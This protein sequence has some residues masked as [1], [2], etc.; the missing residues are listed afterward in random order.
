MGLTNIQSQRFFAI[1][2]NL[3]FVAQKTSCGLG[4]RDRPHDVYNICLTGSDGLLRGCLDGVKDDEL[5]DGRTTI[6]GAIIVGAEVAVQACRNL[7]AVHVLHVPSHR[8][9]VGVCHPHEF[10][11][12]LFL[13]ISLD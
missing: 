6:V 1:G 5:V 7:V 10:E 11:A 9:A 2:F 4:H 3:T 13:Q 12:D 8:E